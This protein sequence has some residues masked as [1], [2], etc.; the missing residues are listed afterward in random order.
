MIKKWNAENAI[1]FDRPAMQ[2]WKHLTFYA[3]L[4]MDIFDVRLV[5]CFYHKFAWI[6][7]VKNQASC[8]KLLEWNASSNEEDRRS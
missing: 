1:V 2:P 8:P 5:D 6:L 7:L 4:H 3:I